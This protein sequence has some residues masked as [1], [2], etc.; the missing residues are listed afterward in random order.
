MLGFGTTCLGRSRFTPSVS[1]RRKYRLSGPL[2][3]PASASI[4]KARFAVEGTSNYPDATFTL[5]LAFGTVQGYG[6]SGQ[7]IPFQ[8]IFAGLYERAAEQKYKPPFDLPE[9]WL[10]RKGRLDLDTPFNFVSTPDITGGNSGSPVVNRKGEFVG[11]VFDG[12]IYSL[13]IDLYYTDKQARAISVHSR[14]IIEALC[15]VYDAKGLVDE[16]LGKKQKN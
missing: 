7:R 11:T 5:P 1:Q 13:V 2:F 15:K 3:S 12:N 6:E 9:R 8:T 4:A 16:L 14:A 10:K